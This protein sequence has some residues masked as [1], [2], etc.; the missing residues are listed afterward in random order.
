M[1]FVPGNTSLC[2]LNRSQL[3]IAPEEI[4]MEQFYYYN[5]TMIFEIRSKQL[6]ILRFNYDSMRYL[7]IYAIF[8][9][10]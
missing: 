5:Q 8:K 3:T 10:K 9:H 4:V 2:S 1:K 6:C 7:H